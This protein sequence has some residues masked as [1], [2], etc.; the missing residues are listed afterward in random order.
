MLSVISIAV[1]ILFCF[2]SPTLIPRLS[3]MARVMLTIRCDS[4]PCTPQPLFCSPPSR[5]TFGSR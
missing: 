1:I 2:T 4:H 3:L 5:V